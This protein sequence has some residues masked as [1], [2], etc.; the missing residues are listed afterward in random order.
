[1]DFS[2]SVGILA[3]I[4]AIPMA[5]IGNLLTPQVGSWWATTTE[6]R[7]QR[8]IA[9]LG[10]E[11]RRLKE[12]GPIQTSRE[13]WNGPK[14]PVL[15]FSNFTTVGMGNP[16]ARQLGFDG[17]DGLAFFVTN[18]ER[19]FETRAHSLKAS[20][21]LQSVDGRVVRVDAAPWFQNLSTAP[22]GSFFKESVTIG[23]L[24]TAGVVCAIKRGVNFATALY[25]TEAGPK[26]GQAI[27]YGDWYLDLR[28]E[29]DNIL[30]EYKGKLQFLP[31]GS[32]GFTLEKS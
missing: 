7:R 29:G 31:N 28:I 1:M 11:L 5:I 27:P 32:S 14:Q 21:T 8:R 19:R 12:R 16:Q 10:S 13:K 6:K 24:E 22:P 18:S 15:E 26:D 25:D 30:R 3:F 20:F 23:M 4:L 17:P 9:K 2:T